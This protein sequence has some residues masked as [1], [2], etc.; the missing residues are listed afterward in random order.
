MKKSALLAAALVISASTAWA[1]DNPT[2][3]FS[4]KDKQPFYKMESAKLYAFSSFGADE[5]AKLEKKDRGS[6]H[7]VNYYSQADMSKILG[8]VYHDAYF[9]AEY[10]KLALLERSKLDLRTVPTPLLDVKKY[11]LAESKSSLLLQEDLLKQQLGNI[12]PVLRVSKLGKYKVITQSYLYKQDYTLNEL[13]ISIIGA[14]NSLYL[15]TSITTDSKYYPELEKAKADAAKEDKIEK[16][17]KE[18]KKQDSASKEKVNALQAEAVKPD[19]LPQELRT[20]LWGEHLKLVKGFRAY[21]PQKGQTSLQFVDTYKGKAVTLP[22]DWVYGQL[23]IKEK[24]ASG[25]LTMAAPIA[26]LR[27]VFAEMD[28]WGLYKSLDNQKDLPQANV[29]KSEVKQSQ[30]ADIA[31]K[32]PEMAPELQ[33][34]ATT[35]ARKVLQSFDAFLMTLSYQTKDRDFVAMADAALASKLG[36]D[37][38]MADTLNSLKKASGGNFVLEN[39]SY[40]LDFTPTKASTAIQARTK[41][42]Q[43][44][45]YDNFLHLALTRESGSM[46]LYAHKPEIVTVEELEKS[47]KEWQF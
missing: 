42:F 2:A 24:E 7:I 44:F 39:Y 38:L 9:T 14:N 33:K 34:T 11:A 25:C 37:A 45:T 19:T 18:Q 41:L 21:A 36:A 22:Q 23:Q 40:S 43:E 17:P 35:E 26:N 12:K 30:A 6:I 28:Y 46:L 29:P 4:V 13:D 3:G 10:E 27:K 20:K 31:D 16:A 15:L 32:L 1:Y 5:L 8:T 47:L